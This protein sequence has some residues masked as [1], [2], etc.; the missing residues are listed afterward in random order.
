[1]SPTIGAMIHGVD[2]S[3]PLNDNQIN[4]IRQAM[5]DYKVVFFRDQDLTTEQHL[6]FARRFG[7]LR[8]APTL[9]A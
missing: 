2:L 3:G 8:T 1:M 6:A 9:Q 4:E 7:G 5:L